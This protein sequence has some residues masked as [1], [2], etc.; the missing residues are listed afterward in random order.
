MALEIT[1]IARAQTHQLCRLLFAAFFMFSCAQVQAEIYKYK[2][3]HG[4]WQFTD[5]KPT[6]DKHAENVKL[7]HNHKPTEQAKLS[8]TRQLIN[9]GS[10][11]LFSA[12]NPIHGPL[13]CVFEVEGGK[14]LPIYFSSQAV[15]EIFQTNNTWFQAKDINYACVIGDPKAEPEN[16]NY[17]VPF[18]GFKSL[19]VTQGFNGRFSHFEEP[20]TYAVDIGMPVGT[21]ISAS[22]DGIVI[23]T[24]DDYAYSGVMSA[25]FFDKAN[26]VQIL[27][28]DG[29]YALYAHLL[30]GKVLVKPGDTVQAGQLLGYSGNSGFSTGPHLH[31]VIQ[32]NN[33]G[34]AKSVKFKFIQSDGLVVTPKRDVWLLPTK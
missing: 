11:A 25:F 14:A 22:R 30:I 33:G 7:S 15:E 8:I 12:S 20:H 23:A 19:R 24:R 27:H 26:Y 4:R 2:D 3:E 13:S 5:K 28:S 32:Y 10:T 34:E 16:Y 21:P 9:N 1:N 18:K 31:F 29:T 6:G 17:L